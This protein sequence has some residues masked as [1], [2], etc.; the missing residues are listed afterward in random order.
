MGELR[1]TSVPSGQF[2]HL[3]FACLIIF[4]DMCCPAPLIYPAEGFGAYV[5]NVQEK[6][7]PTTAPEFPQEICPGARP[8]EDTC[9]SPADWKC[10]SDGKDPS[11]IQGLHRSPQGSRGV[12]YSG[13]VA[14]IRFATV[15]C[16]VQLGYPRAESLP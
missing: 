8:A 6:I 13:T 3:L 14:S 11:G 7:P 2:W 12:P 15:H 10:I 16:F 9:P 1:A 4:A 5:Q